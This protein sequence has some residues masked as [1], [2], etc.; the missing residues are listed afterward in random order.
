MSEE[1]TTHCFGTG[2][3]LTGPLPFDRV[4]RH[5]GPG[6]RNA[7]PD[8]H[9]APKENATILQNSSFLVASWWRAMFQGEPVPW[10]RVPHRN[11]YGGKFRWLGKGEKVGPNNG[12]WSKEVGKTVLRGGK[13]ACIPKGEFDWTHG[14]PLEPIATEAGAT[15]AIGAKALEHRLETTEARLAALEAS[16]ESLTQN[17]GQ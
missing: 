16:L 14:I 9:R 6:Q 5:R 2:P 17:S 8:W 11:A 12:W 1:E 7:D 3:D 10:N 4:G 15:K 13:E